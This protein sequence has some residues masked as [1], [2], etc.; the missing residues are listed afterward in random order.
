MENARRAGRIG[1]ARARSPDENWLR[2]PQDHADGKTFRVD[3]ENDPTGPPP[4]ALQETVSDENGNHPRGMIFG[5]PKPMSELPR[6]MGFLRFMDKV[7]QNADCD[8][9]FSGQIHQMF[10]SHR[11]TERANSLS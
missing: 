1:I 8:L 10:S 2:C 6:R 4:P 5:D 7:G 3:I 9:R 11:E